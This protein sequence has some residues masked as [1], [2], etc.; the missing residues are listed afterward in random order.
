MAPI[1]NIPRPNAPILVKS[2]RIER[3]GERIARPVLRATWRKARGRDQFVLYKNNSDGKGN[4][5]GYHENYLLSRSV[6]FDRIVQVLAPFF[7]T[8]LIYAGAGKVGAE[9]QDQSRRIIRFPS[10]QIFS[11]VSS[12]SIRWSS[13][14]SSIPRDEPHADHGKIP[15][16]STSLSVMR[17][18]RSCRPI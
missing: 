14:R 3:C 4:S 12:I 7:V 15:P 11:S 16:T 2:W 8:R 10:A 9:N 6:P 17:T 18:W 5:Y 13:D 1:R